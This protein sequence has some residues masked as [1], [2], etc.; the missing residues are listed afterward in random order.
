MKIFTID[1]YLEL[2]EEDQNK[3]QLWVEERELTKEGVSF[4]QQ[5]ENNTL[6]L[7]GPDT[8]G[9]VNS[10]HVLK[11]IGTLPKDDFPWEVLDNISQ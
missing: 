6:M 7:S 5:G 8:E 2:T 9:G 10:A 11:L 4:I 3:V 1:D